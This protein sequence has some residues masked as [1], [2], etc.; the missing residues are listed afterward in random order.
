VKI[1]ITGGTTG[2]GESLALA[3]LKRGDTVAVC[4]RD[5]SK[6][7]AEL[8]NHSNLRAYQ[9]SV[10]DRESL[11]NAFKDF[12][13]NG[14]L[15]LVIANAGRSHGHKT[16]TPVFDVARDIIDINVVGVLNTFEEAIKMM[17]P[18]KKGHLVA[19][20]SVAGMVGLPGAAAYSASKA[21]ILKLCESFALD[22]PKI[23]IAVSA[24]APG[25]IDTPL[26]RKNNH[27]MPFLMS[28]DKAANMIV[29]AIDDKR[30]LYAFPKRMWLVM[31]VLERLPRAL[32]RRLM[33]F[34]FMNYSS[35]E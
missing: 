4:G 27:P 32:Y 31:S 8:K 7:S 26:T 3:Y 11:G 21:A 19:I 28:A 22:L 12:C 14:D 35:K 6:L 17:A 23:G 34:K 13:P 20:A 24:I 5:L 15:D 30:V 29:K 9:T 2:I 33:G 16:K 1:F 18:N 10:T 25:F